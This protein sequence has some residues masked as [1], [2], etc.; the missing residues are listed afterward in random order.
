[1]NQSP[2]NKKISKTS[3]ELI[4]L[5]AS[6]NENL[7]R[8]TIEK[9][10]FFN[11]ILVEI[12]ISNEN[13]FGE[14]EKVINHQQDFSKDLRC[15]YCGIEIIRSNFYRHLRTCIKRNRNQSVDVKKIRKRLYLKKVQVFSNVKLST[16]IKPDQKDLSLNGDFSTH[17]IRENGKFGSHP[18][19]DD[20]TEESMP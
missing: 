15:V 13:K 6:K 11:Q 18:I 7:D 20:Y 10:K 19:H 4:L 12:L 16:Q 8:R 9:L 5:L 14:G 17:L 2:I 1:M 3:D